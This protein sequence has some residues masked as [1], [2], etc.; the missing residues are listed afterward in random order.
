M[1]GAM[2]FVLGILGLGTAGAVHTG[3]SISQSK[4]VA[5][6]NRMSGADATGDRRQMYD[7]V[8]K[9]RW[10]I[11]DGQPNCLGKH[12]WDYP[13]GLY[14]HSQDRNWFQA[15]LDAKGIPYDDI[16]LDEVSGVNFDKLQIKMLDDTINGRRRRRR[17]F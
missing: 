12:T 2:S 1:S 3:Q 11:H 5:E 13:G 4:R 6:M 14:M 16:I 17:I 7:R 15:H 9:E 8:R 10:S